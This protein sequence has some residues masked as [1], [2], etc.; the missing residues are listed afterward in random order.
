MVAMRIDEDHRDDLTILQPFG[1]LDSYHSPLLDGVMETAFERGDRDVLLDL[2]DVTYISSRGLRS[3]LIGAKR[4]AEA[5]RRLVVCSP[6]D[7][8]KN[9]MNITGFQNL[10]GCYET[11][12]EAT[13]SLVDKTQAGDEPKC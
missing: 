9:A 13:E 8:V 3:F 11:R 4:A 6:Q 7:F 10:I 1:R 12:A 2:V 5:G